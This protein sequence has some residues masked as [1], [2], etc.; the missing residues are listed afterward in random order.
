[1]GRDLNVDAVLTGKVIKQGDSLYVQ[2]DFVNTADGTQ[3]W[4]E[5]YSRK[6]SDILAVQEEIA[7]RISERLRL[8]LTQHEKQRLTKSYTDNTE[9]YQ[10]YIQGRYYWNKRTDEGLKQALEY[11]QRA[12]NLDPDYALA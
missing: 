6:L 9:A 12:I 4:G 2:A 10:F 1:L 11:F 7:T 8:T 5:R 3:L